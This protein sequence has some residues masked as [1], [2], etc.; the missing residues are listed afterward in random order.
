MASAAAAAA[1]SSTGEA[2]GSKHATPPSEQFKTVSGTN[3]NTDMSMMMLRVAD[4]VVQHTA[5]TDM[6]GTVTK[7][8]RQHI[9]PSTK[10]KS[11][12]VATTAELLRLFV[13]GAFVTVDRGAIAPP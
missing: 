1:A 6:Q 9:Q 12:A 2:Q 4:L 13:I 10:L 8:M 5:H 7:L 11:S 3:T